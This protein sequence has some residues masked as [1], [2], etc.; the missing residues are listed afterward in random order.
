[1][2]VIQCDVP[3][4]SLLTNYS[5]CADQ[6][7]LYVFGGFVFPDYQEDNL[8]EFLPPKTRRDVLPKFSRDLFR[9][10]L[11]GLVITS[12]RG[13][14]EC[15]SSNGS[16][17]ILNEEEILITADPHI[18]LYSGRIV[19]SPTCDLGESFGSCSLSLQAKTRDTYVCF[20]PSCR[21]VIHLKCDKSIRGKS[22][23]TNPMCP[24]CK[25]LDPK[26]WKKN[27]TIS[28]RNRN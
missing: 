9:I 12:C 13:P 25:N 17:L 26:T 27:K 15:G 3:E 4:I 5:F 20:T 22:G 23:G 24:G 2:I 19:Q 10:D 6:N 21:K 1:M 14:E 18:Y 8:F 28:L 16:M 11:L 7:K